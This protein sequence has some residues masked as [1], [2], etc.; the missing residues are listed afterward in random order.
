M[1][2]GRPMQPLATVVRRMQPLTQGKRET[3]FITWVGY[4]IQCS[5]RPSAMVVL[6]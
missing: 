2:T 6:A 1:G 4:T 3:G 5:A